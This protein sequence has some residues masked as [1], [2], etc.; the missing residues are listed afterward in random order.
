MLW[1][2][3]AQTIELSNINLNPRLHVPYDHSA[4]PSQTDRQTD[5]RTDEHHDNTA[6]IRSNEH[7]AR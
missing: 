3:G 2:Q 1:C 6:K 7:I 5:R 4:H